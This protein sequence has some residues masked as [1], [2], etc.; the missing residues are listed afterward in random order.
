[1]SLTAGVGT[2]AATSTG[3]CPKSGNDGSAWF[4][5]AKSESSGANGGSSVSAKCG[6]GRAAY[7]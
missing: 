2:P 6:G 3:S 5:R 7:W 1:M 4:Q